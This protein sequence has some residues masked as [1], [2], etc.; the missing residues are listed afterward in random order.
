MVAWGQ[1]SAPAAKQADLQE[2]VVTGTLLRGTA[3]TGTNVIAVTREDIVAKGVASSNDLLATIPQLGYFGTVPRGNQDAGSPLV[4]PNIRNLGAS[5]GST[6][7]VLLNGH[8]LVGAGVLSTSVDPSIIPPGMIE[9]VDVMPDGGSSIY[10]S[11]AIGGVINFVT[12]NRFDGIQA[13]GRYGIADKYKTADTD[14]VLGRDWGSRSLLV[15]YA[16]AWH[17]DLLGIDRDYATANHMSQGGS[18][19]RNT[20]CTPGNITIGA[21]SFAL[22]A[23]IPG[24]LNRCD[25]PKA[26]DIYPRER[27]HS[28]YGSFVQQLSPTLEFSTTGYWS[29]RDTQ[30]RTA[31]SSQTGTIRAA[32]PYFRPIGTE[33]SHNVAFSYAGVFGPSNISNHEFQ[34]YGVTP[35]LNL[36]VGDRWQIRSQTNFGRS[37]NIVHEDLANAGAAALALAGTTTA[38]ALNPYDLGQTNP[39][40]LA[41]IGNF[42][43]LGT[44]TQELAEGRIVADGPLLSL[45]GGDL[46]VAF[47]GEYHYENL[48]Q[49][50]TS[51]PRGLREGPTLTYSS[52]SDSSR[53]VRSAYAEIFVPIFGAGNG[54]PGLRSLVLSGSLRHDDYSDVGGTTNPKIGL[55]YKPIDDLVIRGNYGTSFHT[56]SLADSAS[57]V[58]SQAQI[59]QVS[60]FRPVGSPIS[61]LFR[62]TIIIAGGNSSL[63]PETADTWS[64]GFDWSPRAI[65]GLSLSATYFNVDFTNAIGLVSSATL[66]TD[67]NFAPF[68]IINPTLE[69]ARA[70]VGSRTI[71]GAPSVESLYAGRS[72]FLLVDA[73]INNFG[74]IKTDGI[75]FDLSYAH[76]AGP[77]VLRAE[78]AGT[79]ALSRKLST[80][81]SGPFTDTLKNGSGRFS[82]VATLGAK[83]AQLTANASINFRG[84][85]PLRG[86]VNQTDIEDFKTVDLFFGYE[87]PKR[88][89]LADTQLT[90]NLENA[91]DESPPYINN[92]VGYANGSTLGRLISVGLRKNAF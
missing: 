36:D 16:Y 13:T 47:G 43:N 54:R 70:A 75:D 6:T 49:H 11:D 64:A 69:Q 65:E 2:V 32:N 62:P 48:R 30:I 87:L 9:R 57:T 21:T 52:R 78:V 77:A 71:V 19:V 86:L 17:E 39:A 83:V 15:G 35:S 41:T 37:R 26:T 92:N 50:L 31:R 44:A 53:N 46:R 84:G 3:P 22:P 67:P 40:V 20:A 66:F 59:L 55:N 5:G 89:F 7:L 74:S 81:R 90:L 63:Q 58:G 10:G 12:R 27:R 38:T 68:F 4:R 24:T 34:S 60:P 76:G 73:R 79:Y 82:Y 18:D 80:G 51:G 8:R 85:Y 23:R 42:E 45:P 1:D 88:G 14:L 33:S 56:P 91:F 28:V 61:D 25:D 29:Q 72:P